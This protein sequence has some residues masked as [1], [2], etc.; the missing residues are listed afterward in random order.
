MQERA[1]KLCEAD[2]CMLY[3]E[4]ERGV[5]I[6][7]TCI[8]DMLII[9][10]EEAIDDAIRV[11]QGHF[12]VKDPTS[13]EDC[14]GVQ[15]VQNDD[16]KK[17]WLG[18]P[19]RP[20]SL[21]KQFGEKVAKKKMT[22]TPGT[23]GSI[24]GKVDDISKVDEN[25]QSMYRSG[26]GTLLYLTKHSKPVIT[27]PV[28]E[29]SKSMDGASMAQVTEMYRVINF[30]L[31]MK[32]LGL[33]MVPTFKGGIWKLEA[34]SDSDFA[35]DKDTRYSVYGYIIYFCGVPVAWKSKSMKS[36]VLSST[37]AGDQVCVPN[38][39]EHGDKCTTTYQGSNGQCW[40][41]LVGK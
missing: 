15:I 17:A 24:G 25:T 31:E 8:D 10:K 16:G 34:L 29:L 33:M 4:D 38:A 13:L 2:P 6:I 7:I 37:E 5:C 12:Q 3:K 41:N 18:Q 36:V 26:V 28:R 11:L 1:F 30:V 21:E 23:P 39:K 9:G 35:N 32:T 19:T 40:C 27:N 14:L 20:K 22:I